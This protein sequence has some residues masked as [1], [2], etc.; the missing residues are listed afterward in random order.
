MRTFCE[1][2]VFPQTVRW[3]PDVASPRVYGDA[4]SFT[5]VCLFVFGGRVFI[6]N[7]S[8]WGEGGRMRGKA[9]SIS[10]QLQDSEYAFLVPVHRPTLHEQTS[11]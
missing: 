1:F 11:V 3:C 9:G 10:G 4:S 5:F 7:Q 6:M 2:V 8:S